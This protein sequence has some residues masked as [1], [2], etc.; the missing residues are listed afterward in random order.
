MFIR[1]AYF[2]GQPVAGQAE[3]LRGHLEAALQ[4]YMGFDKIQSA[5]LYVS[6][7]FEEGAPGIYATLQLCFACEADLLAALATPFRQEMRAYFAEAVFPL[8]EGSVKH[9][10]HEVTEQR[11]AAAR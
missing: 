11:G 8:F 4:R 9:I 3:A 10:N 1:S 6:Q 7:E 5:Q 2:I